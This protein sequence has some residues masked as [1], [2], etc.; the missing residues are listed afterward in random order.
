MSRTIFELIAQELLNMLPQAP[1]SE[2]SSAHGT[3]SSGSLHNGTM[4]SPRSGISSML[5]GSNASSI[6]RN[7]YI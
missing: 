2:T 7:G 5:H 4:L 3:P 6:V 1:S